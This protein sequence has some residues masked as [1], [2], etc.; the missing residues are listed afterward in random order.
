M[1]AVSPE[2]VRELLH[3]GYQR[4][5]PAPGLRA[6]VQ[7]YWSLQ[8]FTAQARS[9][10][11][12]PDGGT[13][14]VFDF[15]N[16]ECVWFSGQRSARQ[17]ALEGELHAFGIRFRP[18]GA[19][20]LLG[21]SPVELGQGRITLNDVLLPQVS[22]LL[23]QFASD[24]IAQRVARADAWLKSGMQTQR[25]GPVQWAWPLLDDVNP[26]AA[27]ALPVSRRTLER[28]FQQ[29]VGLSPHQLLSLL[30]VKRARQLIKTSSHL[31]LA[32]VA[33]AC[34]YYD[35]AHFSREFLLITGRS[36]GCY[37][38]RQIARLARG[39]MTVDAFIQSSTRR[40]H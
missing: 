13:S 9:E 30:R 1:S 24:N 16:R 26:L 35:Q 29:E 7:C 31:A 25:P 34:G 5:T 12:Y 6:W 15:A 22:E 20:A 11:L 39:E 27:Q 18:G 14:L 32:E 40:R 38:Q 28:R 10:T 37:R 2:T 17:L 3:L 4:A 33:Q 36:P 8:G 23:E 21:I 19:F